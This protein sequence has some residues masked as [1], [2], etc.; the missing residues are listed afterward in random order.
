MIQASDV[1]AQDI[2]TALMQETGQD[3]SHLTEAQWN[4]LV[5]R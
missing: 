4:E 2:K 3:L 5:E 1:E